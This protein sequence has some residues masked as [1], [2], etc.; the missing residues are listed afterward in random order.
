VSTIHDLSAH[1][2]SPWAPARRPL[3]VAVALATFILPVLHP[4]LRPML[5]A[6]SH[7]LW[8]AHAL[9]ITLSGYAFGTPGFVAAAAASALAVISGESVFGAG[10]GHGADEATVLALV[11]AVAFTN[12]LTGLFALSVRA[13]QRRR[14]DLGQLVAAALSTSVDAVLVLDTDGQ[15]A[16]ANGA[17]CALFGGCAVDL[18]GTAISRLIE[19]VDGAK[20]RAVVAGDTATLPARTLGDAPFAAEVAVSPVADPSHGVV[21]YLLTIRDQSQRLRQDDVEHRTR[22]LAQLGEA[23][24]SIA[25]EINNPLAAVITLSQVAATA[26]GLPDGLREDLVAIASEAARATAIARGLLTRLRPATAVAPGPIDLNAIVR[27]AL[28]VRRAGFAAHGIAV[29]AQ[30]SDALAPVPAN[31]DEIHQVLANLLANAEHAMHSA[32]GRG[33]LTVRTRVAGDVAEITVE[34]DGPG[35]SREH[36]LRLFEPFFTT[37]P[38]G[39]GT[40]LGLSIARRIARTHGGDLVAQSEPGAGAAFTLRLPVAAAATP[41]AEDTAVAIGSRP[42]RILVVDDE[43]G[44]RR[45]L[46]RLLG[47]R[48][49]AV[50]VAESVASAAGVLAAND[51]WDVV[52]CDDRLG[53]ESGVSLY[54]ATA[55]RNPRL[56]ARFVF[57]SGDLANPELQALLRD[58]HIRSLSKPFPHA[59]LLALVEDVSPSASVAAV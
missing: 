1:L 30:F 40:G 51:A 16:Y 15:V 43:P 41:A 9:S 31:P 56:A 32:H 10:Y 14:R 2:D 46:E 36:V 6:P 27:H 55:A 47:R 12:G 3:L 38:V 48:G 42:R 39:V 21:A 35:I 45:A 59:E 23:V 57:M 17:A 7:L 44:V 8:F 37:K 4:L 20:L 52:L 25:H 19:D 50:Q 54:R 26:P 49:H 5:G 58:R 24:G 53:E 33:T 28:R 11:V 34:D 29:V 18:R 13:E 22:A